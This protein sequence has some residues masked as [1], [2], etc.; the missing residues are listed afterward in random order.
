VLSPVV[1]W[2]LQRWGLSDYLLVEVY[3]AL[4]DLASNPVDHL[5]RDPGGDPGAL[6][7]FRR[8]DPDDPRF[9]HLFQFRVFYDEDEQH[10][11]IVRGSYWRY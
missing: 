8:T 7:V 10:L 2:Q 4:Q 3:L 11:H 9:R 6:Y 1:K 5:H